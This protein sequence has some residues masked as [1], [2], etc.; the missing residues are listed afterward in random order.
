MRKLYQRVLSI[1]LAIAL[2]FSGI[3]FGSLQDP[4]EVKAWTASD[5]LSGTT[6]ASSG[7][8]GDYPNY[9]GSGY[10]V[11]LVESDLRAE[12]HEHPDK[13]PNIFTD[14]K[15]YLA[16]NEGFGVTKSILFTSLSES[17]TGTIYNIWQNEKGTHKTPVQSKF[18]FS[19]MSSVF[20]GLSNAGLDLS[21]IELHG[22]K[23]ETNLSN[24][25]WVKT[26]GAYIDK[27]FTKAL[28]YFLGVFGT[29][30]E[31][32]LNPNYQYC[33]VVEPVSFWKDGTTK[34][35]G[36]LDVTDKS[37][38]K[39]SSKFDIAMNR[40]KDH[41]ADY[42][43]TILN[44][45]SKTANIIRACSQMV[46][47]GEVELAEVFKIVRYP[48]SKDVFKNGYSVYGVGAN[49]G[50]TGKT[51]TSFS[52]FY[53]D[54]VL[55]SGGKLSVAGSANI[56]TNVSGVSTDTEKFTLSD[57][58]K[59]V[60]LS[61]YG[62][63]VV[64]PFEKKGSSSLTN[65]VNKVT[66][67]NKW[68]SVSDYNTVMTGVST[69][70]FSSVE[71]ASTSEI[72]KALNS[73][74]NKIKT[75]NVNTTKVSITDSDIGIG[76]MH[77]LKLNNVARNKLTNY[78][79]NYLATQ[80][81]VYKNSSAKSLMFTK[82]VYW[83]R[84]ASYISANSSFYALAQSKGLKEV[85]AKKFTP[86]KKSTKEKTEASTMGVSV[87]LYAKKKVATSY[88]AFATL[89][90]SNKT[91]KYD[92]N[93]KSTY[94]ITNHADFSIPTNYSN[95][96][97]V[98][99]PSTSYAMKDNVNGSKIFN[100]LKN[101]EIAD[102]S[103]LEEAV[104][105]MGYVV[106]SS[107]SAEGGNTI[108]VGSDD[109]GRGYGVLVL[110][111]TGNVPQK[112]KLNLMEYELN[113]VFPSM[114]N[115]KNFESLSGV[116]SYTRYKVLRIGTKCNKHI[117]H[118]YESSNKVKVTTSDTYGGNIISKNNT[119]GSNKNIL[120]NDGIFNNKTRYFTTEADAHNKIVRNNI[121]KFTFSLAV[122]L[123]RSSFGDK[124]VISTM[125]KQT[126][127]K[128]FA[129]NN[130][131]LSYG[132]KPSTNVLSAKKKRT[133]K[134]LLRVTRTDNFHWDTKFYFNEPHVHG[135]Y[136]YKRNI[137]NGR[138]DVCSGHPHRQVIWITVGKKKKKQVITRWT[139]CPVTYYQ[140][141]EMTNQGALAS[142]ATTVRYTIN[143][144]AYKYDSAEIETVENEV[145]V[146]EDSLQVSDS[147]LNSNK[148]LI[149][150]PYKIA[151]V[152]SSNKVLG[153]YPEITMRAYTTVGDTIYSSD[154][155]RDKTLSSSY[156]G[157]TPHNV[158]M[159]GEYRRTLKPSSM[160]TIK[161]NAGNGS[162]LTGKTI[163]D[164]TAVGSNA[165]NIAGNLPV[166]YAGGNISLN[167]K[168]NLSL[169]MY[170]YSLDLIEP[171]DNNLN[172][173][174]TPYTS[175]V[176]DGTNV[177]SVWGNTGFK[178]LA[179]FNTWIKDTLDKLAVD[180]TLTVNGSG[181]DKTYN[182]FATSLGNLNT[183][184]ATADGVFNIQI[185]QGKIVQNNGYKA[186]LA[187]IRSDY[188]LTTVAQA[189]KLFKESE[190]Y[191]TIADA[192]EDSSDAFNKSSK[193]N[194]IDGSRKHWYDEEVKTFVVRRYKKE[195]IKIGNVL[196]NDKLDYG[197]APTGDTYV[198]G[199][200]SYK[201]ATAKWYMTLY[202]KDLPE[203]FDGEDVYDPEDYD[204]LSNAN[205]SGTVLVNELYVSGADFVIPSA[206]THDMGNRW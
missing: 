185:K 62:T 112:S 146:L 68:S 9:M 170:S 135:T 16:G 97:Y 46:P 148:S 58:N 132:V 194:A 27:N 187:Q 114:L 8:K 51:G 120:R 171:S 4:V 167:I 20:K 159:I 19:K 128:N 124:R 195:N 109:K 67:Y 79:A 186:L 53:S 75:F 31:K 196:V 119:L 50:D 29:S 175:V 78:V 45:D 178:P 41:V 104:E 12:S 168:S 81:S 22:D 30:A 197:S 113:Y 56:S 106:E 204:G 11:Y 74:I 127:N 110:Q 86:T 96:V 17:S 136:T 131:D 15:Y 7:S 202:F 166:I 77:S 177:K 161:V 154:T 111:L 1:V 98:A 179:E 144:T 203:G 90:R 88:V 158:V 76:V 33:F 133:S 200:D 63:N 116:T 183:S 61:S 147:G 149:S 152:T 108:G 94:A 173:T 134:S 150:N 95:C 85:S 206:S 188:G 140:L 102:E 14:A 3:S 69:I 157:V 59:N 153:F 37:G 125:S 72:Y 60:I 54:T 55:K 47:S 139:Y 66:G 122:N 137:Y 192:V 24:D 5:S 115:K 193:S 84:P 117:T 39:I 25:Y 182:N 156:S 105:S 130:L 87:T 163:S 190:I 199:N 70:T 142:G 80:S 65:A 35:L 23:I 145:G 57:S 89:D 32:A 48:T 83:D 82:D 181:V 129:K 169:S 107:G 126:I 165:S 138:Y 10:R 21:P 2:V 36:W 160:R 100:R 13:Y 91:I 103:D 151:L 49:K 93:S 180:T 198:T 26:F 101:M 205:D 141:V 40:G 118:L 28:D 92:G 64:K 123:T 164:A 191:Q 52:L 99:I 184:S 71:N 18:R 6:S 121:S 44:G 176:A 155:A 143:E 43:T 201:K 174:S 162:V 42:L 38:T 34:A 189:E 172:G 73:A